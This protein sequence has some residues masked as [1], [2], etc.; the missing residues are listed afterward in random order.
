[1]LDGMAIELLV[2]HL[3]LNASPPKFFLFTSFFFFFYLKLYYFIFRTDLAGFVQFISFLA[4]YN[5][6]ENP[7]IVDI[8]NSFLIDGIENA[9]KQ[10]IKNRPVLPLLV[11]ITPEDITGTM[12]KFSFS[13]IYFIINVIFSFTSL[14]PEPVVFL[15]L[16]K[17]ATVMHE[18]ICASAL[19]NKIYSKFVN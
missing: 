19:T 18:R 13:K 14:K 16:I 3:F 8:N 2:A 17:L 5:F 7:V 15:R 9:K 12:Y 10:F 11:I 4:T 6:I 1:M